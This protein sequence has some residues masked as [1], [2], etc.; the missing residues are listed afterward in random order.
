M[1]EANAQALLS[2]EVEEE[3]GFED[4]FASFGWARWLEMQAQTMQRFARF[5]RAIERRQPKLAMQ[6]VLEMQ[7]MT[8]EW[9][10]EAGEWLG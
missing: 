6:V 9:L 10:R 5:Q 4:P 8:A 7:Q 1:S 2:L 3:E